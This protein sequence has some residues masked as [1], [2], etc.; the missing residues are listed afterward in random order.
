MKV[1]IVGGGGRE[2]ALAWKISRSPEVE[3]IYC[4]PGNAGISG[5]A[6]C[7]AID[8]ED[9]GALKDFALENQIDL[10]AVGPEAP[11]VAGIA[12]VFGQAGLRV[13]GPTQAA[14]RIEG[15]KS[16]AKKLM[17]KYNIPT[18][19]GRSFASYEHAL[20]YLESAEY[21]LVIKADGLAA[22]K[23]VVVC[24]TREEA[25]GALDRIMNQRVYGDAGAAV[26]I[27]AFMAGEEASFIAFTDGKTVVPLPTSQDH[28]ALGD[29]DTG[30]NTGGMGAVSPTPVVDI[31][32][33]QKI[34]NQVMIPTVKA[35]A[36]EGAPFKGVLYAGLMIDGDTARVVEF[37]CRFGDPET[38]PILM[39]TKS[40]IVPLMMACID[41]GLENYSL[42]IDPRPAACV[43]L[44]AKGY[45]EKYDKGVP[46]TGLDAAKADPD[47]RLFH[48]GT[49]EK[50]GSVV[51]AGG[52]VLG[53]T[54][55]GDTMEIALQ[56][57][58]E[59][60]T[61][62]SFENMYHRTD[63]GHR[64]LLRLNTPA[65][66]GIV[67]GSDS[68]LSVMAAAAETLRQFGITYEF[69]VCS[70]HRT[71]E[72][73]AVFGRSARER[74]IKMIIAGAGHAAHLAGAMAA[75]SSLPIIGVPIDS[76]ALNGFDALLSTVQMPPGMPVATMAVGKPGAKNAAV[77]A[78]QVLSVSDPGLAKKV[79]AYKKKM[80]A[81]VNRKAR[82]FAG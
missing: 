40:D 53:A 16:F 19:P 5:I 70:A 7:I 75:H 77:F 25:A 37:N 10:T 13:F 4:A 1:L 48:S 21:P 15:S 47:A 24:Q 57:A 28:K 27:E 67:M 36:A 81:D 49:I 61:R 39:R 43:I 52:R 20:A 45:P 59:T 9:I 41:G 51:T 65:Q 58:Y 14:A 74:G 22:G 42:E 69:T 63:I 50:E 17:M 78:A 31:V 11:L 73:A 60:A 2:H 30:P 55:I 29:G 12:D 76:S 38:Q 66:V 62:V 56:R 82:S 23:G 54:A 35:M 44:A 79:D 18:A 8:S 33:R 32:M 64:T 71:P 72:E 3:A 46:V 26:L 34:I 6:E 80:A 68:D